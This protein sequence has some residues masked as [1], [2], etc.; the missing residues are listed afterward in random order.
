[1]Y[2]ITDITANEV[3]YNDVDCHQEPES[4]LCVHSSLK[5]KELDYTY[6]F[7]KIQILKEAREKMFNHQHY[8]DNQHFNRL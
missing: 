6:I 1:M 5:G 3:A 4:T 7:K 2:P 8:Q